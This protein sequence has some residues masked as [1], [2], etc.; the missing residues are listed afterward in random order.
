MNPQSS[1]P[2]VFLHSLFRSGSTYLFEVFRRSDENYW[3][4]QEP[5]NELLLNVDSRPDELLK[6]SA[7]MSSLLR[8]PKLDKPYFW[9]FHEIRNEITGLFRKRFCYDDF[10]PTD[11]YDFTELRA[12]LGA[13][14][15]N[16]RGQPVFQCCRSFGRAAFVKCEVKD[17]IHIYLWRNPRDQW[18]S[19]KVASFFDTTNLLILNANNP[20]SVI[21]DLRSTLAFEE[22][23]DAD[24]SR[25]HAHFD[26]HHLP[27]EQSYVLFYTLWCY[28][29]L[30]NR[31]FADLMI[32]ID[33]LSDSD[34]Y[35]E[36]VRT[37]IQG[38]N[39]KGIDFSD[40]RVPQSHY[41]H[42]E[43]DFFAKIEERVHE[44]F[45]S[46]GF[47]ETEID[48]IQALRYEHAPAATRKGKLSAKQEALIAEAA[49]ARGASLRLERELVSQMLKHQQTEVLFRAKETECQTMQLTLQ[50]KEL[51]QQQMLAMVQSRNADY[52][53]LKIAYQT[54][55]AERTMC[56]QMLGEK[57]A[58]IQ[59]IQS[60]LETKESERAQIESVLAKR[61][62]DLQVLGATLEE[63]GSEANRLTL[64]C[65]ELRARI[66]QL[67]GE[68]EAS[69]SRRVHWRNIADGLNRG[70]SKDFLPLIEPLRACRSFSPILA[71]RAVRST[72]VLVADGILQ[73]VKDHI[74]GVPWLH[75]RLRR[76]FLLARSKVSPARNEPE[77]RTTIADL[78][79]RTAK[80]LADLL[81][82]CDQIER[83]R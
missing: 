73:Q 16:A 76:I 75:S 9:E 60:C 37:Q 21:N 14:I 43:D 61:D 22:F 51:E 71:A 7:E 35:R 11:D 25:E 30:K 82:E 83:F 2:P 57:T 6:V 13:L 29:L 20:P 80:V 69:K 28:G 34:A 3:C 53:D 1:K 8:H 74:R 47:G 40:C 18:W 39:I 46:H 63:E 17:A 31:Q 38:L 33:S 10:F 67:E 48:A 64:E 62:R 5:L 12:Y 65:C 50:A 56:Q 58:L 79:P 49:R 52:G 68:I 54:L 44:S 4:Y 81:R 59:Q 19:Y 27:P 70:W 26:Q 77:T 24:I 15:L 23:H 78:P 72:V 42:Q 32:S 55:E 41:S 66:Q 45:I 36:K